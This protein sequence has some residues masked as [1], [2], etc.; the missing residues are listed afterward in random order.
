MRIFAR[1]LGIVLIFLLAGAMA[2]EAAWATTKIKNLRMWTAPDHTRVVFDVGA[3]VEHSLFSLEK[4]SKKPHR[5]VIDIPDARMG[6]LPPRPKASEPLLRGIRFAYHNQGNRRSLR[7]V[8]DLKRPVYPKSFQLSPNRNYGHRL[9]VDLYREP[10]SSRSHAQK[11]ASRPSAPKSRPRAPIKLRNVVVAIDPGHGGEDVGATG[12]RGTREKDVVLAIGK[13]LKT[14][15]K[16]ERG[17]DAFLVRHG[18][19]YVGLKKRTRIARDHKADLF[20]SIHADAFRDSTVYGSSVYVLSEGGAS[21]EAAKW[22]ADREN[23]ADLVGGVSL[24]DKDDLLA[25]VLLDL[26]QKAT[27][28]DSAKLGADVLYQLGKLGKTHKRQLQRAGFMVLKSPDIPS[29]LVE[30]AFI[31]NPVEEKRLRSPKHQRRVAEAILRGVLSYF[32]KN[33]PPNTLLASRE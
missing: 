33:P 2:G 13:Q 19:Y 7:V 31:S 14:L 1:I 10:D 28:N 22:L 18:D 6:L 9:V 15:L 27:L 5:V 8:L 32:K 12:R 30:T 23:S 25:T 17:I 21:S 26:S 24:N 3:P 4:S 16:R 29:I 20:I 11:P